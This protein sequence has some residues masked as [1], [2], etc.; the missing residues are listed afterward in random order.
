[1]RELARVVRPGGR[2]AMLEFSVPPGA[3]ARRVGA[4][5]PRRAAGSPGRAVSPG[6]GEVGDFLGPSIREFWRAV[7]A[8]AAARGLGG[9]RDRGRRRRASSASAA[10]SSCGA[11]RGGLRPAVPRSTRSR[12]GGWRDY[13]TLLHP[14]YTAWHLSYVAIGAAL[15]PALRLGPLLCRR[16]PRSSS[17]SG[18]ART[19]STSSTGGRCRRGSRGRARRARRRLDRGRRRDR[20]SSARSRSS[21]GS[22]AFVAVGAFIVVAYNLELARGRFHSDAWFALSWGAFPLLT[23]YFAAAGELELVALLGR[24]SSRTS[25]AGRSARSRRPCRD[26]RRRVV[27]VEGRI[28]RVDGTSEPVTAALLVRANESALRALAAGV[29]ALAVGLVLM[30]TL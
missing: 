26:L 29:V 20:R 25:S 7:S 23:A 9:R 17:R 18:S 11:R 24:R 6:W 14:P 4:L 16:S 13:V 22:R 2:I 5:R 28:D 1:M 10:A 12:P 3:P 27:H 21:R 8:R 19:R 30:R 15:A